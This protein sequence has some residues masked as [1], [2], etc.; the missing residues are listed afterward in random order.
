MC[1]C[2]YTGGKVTILEHSQSLFLQNKRTSEALITQT[3]RVRCSRSITFGCE[4]LWVSWSPCAFWREAL[5]AGATHSAELRLGLT[6]RLTA[7]HL[8]KLE[9]ITCTRWDTSS[10]SS[11]K[12]DRRMFMKHH[13][14]LCIILTRCVRLNVRAARIDFYTYVSLFPSYFRRPHY[15]DSKGTL[16]K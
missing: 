9:A 11:A 14:Y 16:L 10:S 15:P 5:S 7:G 8:R 13:L 3:S 2:P 6:E 1:V 12:F 4:A